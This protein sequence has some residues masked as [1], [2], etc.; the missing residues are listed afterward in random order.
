MDDEAGIRDGAK[1]AIDGEWRVFYGGYWIKAYDAPADTLLAKK[2]LIEA[3]TRRLFNHVEHGLNIPGRAARGG[4]AR[5]RRRDRS[6]QAA[7]QGGD[8]GR[9]ALQPRRRSVH[10]GGRAAGAGDRDRSGQRADARSAASTCKRRSRSGAWCF[11]AAATRA[12]TSCGASRSRR[13]PSRSR[14]STRAATSR[15]PSPCATSIGI[16]DALCETFGG[17]ATPS[18]ASCRPSASSRARPS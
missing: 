16:A 9:R 3:L 12:S 17:I 15:S 5:L 13:S 1:R 7:G 2:T 4:A 18:P 11:I 14:T 8:A 6:A 10:Q